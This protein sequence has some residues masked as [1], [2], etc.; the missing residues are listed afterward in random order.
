V[1]PVLRFVRGERDKLHLSYKKLRYFS[2]AHCL[3]PGDSWPRPAIIAI[4]QSLGRFGSSI[5]ASPCGASMRLSTRRNRIRSRCIY[6]I[7]CVCV[8][9]GLLFCGAS[10]CFDGGTAGVFLANGDRPM[11]GQMCL[12]WVGGR[13]HIMWIVLSWHAAQSRRSL[14]L[15]QTTAEV[16]T[17]S[18]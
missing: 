13:V 16:R 3:P 12:P 9:S 18:G 6:E 8:I 2:A 17:V 1:C 11:L 15:S 7:P 10:L 5:A 14:L 4:S